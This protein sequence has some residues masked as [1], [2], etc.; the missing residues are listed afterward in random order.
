MALDWTR[1]GKLGANWHT[2]AMSI[3]VLLI[4]CKACNR[5]AALGKDD[6]L[7]I[8][9]GNVLVDDLSTDGTSKSR[10]RAALEQAEATVVRTFVLLD[11]GV[12]PSD[13]KLMSLM[14]LADIIAA[15]EATKRLSSDALRAVRIGALSR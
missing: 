11:Y 15:G 1:W 8:Y 14:T 13:Q 2:V 7:P 3:E 10:F 4:E 12:F 9:Q 5:R 6:G